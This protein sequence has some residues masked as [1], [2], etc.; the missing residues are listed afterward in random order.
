MQG[1]F[2]G[3]SFGNRCLFESGE[4]EVD[5]HSL[6]LL[7]GANGTGK[8]TLLKQLYMQNRDYGIYIEQ[9]NEWLLS[10]ISIAENISMGQDY[11]TMRS[12]V[13]ILERFDMG[14]LIKK[15]PGKISGGE[16]RIVCLLRGLLSDAEFIFIDEPTND[17]D[18]RIVSVLLELIKIFRKKKTFLIV[19]HDERLYQI[20]D[21]IYVI[22]NQKIEIAKNN[23][24]QVERVDRK[25]DEKKRTIIC[26]E[27]FFG[28]VFRRDIVSICMMFFLVLITVVFIEM[29]NK[30][31][32]ISDSYIKDNQINICNA[33]YAS[34]SKLLNEGYLPTSCLKYLDTEDMSECDLDKIA[35]ELEECENQAYSLHLEIAD[36]EKYETFNLQYYDGINDTF[37]YILDI[38]SQMVCEGTENIQIVTSD[39]FILDDFF[40]E[41]HE[42]ENANGECI[43]FALEKFKQAE[44]LIAAQGKSTPCFGIVVLNENI[45]FHDFIQEEELLELWEGNYFIKSAET[46]ELVSELNQYVKQKKYMERYFWI[47]LFLVMI[48]I[49]NTMVTVKLKKKS[50]RVLRDYG[51]EEEIVLKKLNLKYNMIRTNAILCEIVVLWNL[52]V[53]VFNKVNI[54]Y[55]RFM[56]AGIF[57]VAIVICFTLRRYMYM[58]AVRKVYSDK[59]R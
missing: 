29:S 45:S 8:S 4:I 31:E 2:D 18:Y 58:A 20:A 17:L 56:F 1:K 32:L 42:I 33:L 9:D 13:K 41:E 35:S 24:G 10:H 39:Y 7:T 14:E 11:V 37:Y 27:D 19:T 51:F 3:V 52:L 55:N 26:N 12:I 16:E 53:C 57:A 50:I 59:E 34:P 21:K 22:Q 40:I 23:N 54:T 5:D 36:S 25:I 43:E 44:N 48:E 46:V 6:V 47:V 30:K 28:R 38:Y 49:F 15:Q